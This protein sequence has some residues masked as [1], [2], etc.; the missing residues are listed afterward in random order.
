ML[1]RLVLD[2]AIDQLVDERA[3]C[4]PGR[5]S[6]PCPSRSGSSCRC[7]SC[8]ATKSVSMNGP[9]PLTFFQ[10]VAPASTTSLGMITRV[11]APGQPIVPLGVVFLEVEDDG[12]LVLGHDIAHEVVVGRRAFLGLERSRLKEKTTSSAVSSRLCMTPGFS[13]NMMPLRRVNTTDKRVLDQ[14]PLL[15]ELAALR[16][17]R[18]IGVG[19]EGMLAALALALVEVARHQLLVEL[20][21]VVVQL[22]VP[23]VR[24]PRQRRQGREHRADFERAAVLRLLGLL[25]P[26]PC[27]PPIASNAA[28][29]PPSNARLR[30]FI[31]PS[32]HRS[33]DLA[34]P[35]SS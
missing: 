27:A 26:G 20:A 32:S 30:V 6:S 15:G 11:E 28:A 18:E 12:V 3:A 9:V 34:G 1:G 35:R 25:A 14:L 10:L 16:L 21:G 31:V 2:G 13:G 22:P 23:V 5:R 24:I 8:P 29:A 17:G 19:D 4:S 7:W 33:A